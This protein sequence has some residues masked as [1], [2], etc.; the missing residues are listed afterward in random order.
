[1]H[2]ALYV[3]QSRRQPVNGVLYEIEVP[4]KSR[5]GLS[6]D[7][8]QLA[9][10]SWECSCPGFRYQAREDGLCTHLDDVLV[11]AAG[12]LFLAEIL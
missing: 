3:E 1:M 10:G 9:D 4:S 2:V 11:M 8:R 7:V 12:I 5:P 6:Y